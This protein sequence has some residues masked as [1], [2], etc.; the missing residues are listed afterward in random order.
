MGKARIFVVGSSLLDNNFG[1]MKTLNMT[2][3]IE[4]EGELLNFALIYCFIRRDWSVTNP[5]SLYEGSLA[6]WRAGE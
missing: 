4:A 2:R 3:Q 1:Y 5:I 6:R